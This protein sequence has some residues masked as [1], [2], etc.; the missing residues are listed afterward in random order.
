MSEAP[1]VEYEP[2][3]NDPLSV[4]ESH[5][6]DVHSF[7][8]HISTTLRR[9]E[10]VG[11][12]VRFLR[13]ESGLY[14]PL[15]AGFYEKAYPA[16]SNHSNGD[17]LAYDIHTMRALAIA[18]RSAFVPD[19]H[20]RGQYNIHDAQLLPLLVNGR[21]Q[22][23]EGYILNGDEVDARRVRSGMCF[24]MRRVAAVITPLRIE[25]S[26]YEENKT[27]ILTGIQNVVGLSDS[28]IDRVDRMALEV[29]TH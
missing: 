17:I 23:V 20:A 22:E 16:P 3:V 19:K 15:V 28:E 2:R 18:A 6:E 29:Q 10:H 26:F 13:P 27:E 9:N 14:N 12:A 24:G 8:N 4:I 21:G 7:R 25:R 5:W 11:D 1:K